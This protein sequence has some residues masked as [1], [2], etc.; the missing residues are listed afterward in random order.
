MIAYAVETS[1]HIPRPLPVMELNP[2]RTHAHYSREEITAG[3]DW[4]NLQRTPQVMRQGVFHAPTR[5]A[6]ALMVTLR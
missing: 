5:N 4:A 1:R 3:L 6:D 2:F